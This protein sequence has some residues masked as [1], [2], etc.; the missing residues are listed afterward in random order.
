MPEA[1]VRV[2]GRCISECHLA[3][4]TR[5]FPRN[6]IALP[7]DCILGD[8]FEDERLQ[9]ARFFHRCEVL[10]ALSRS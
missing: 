10:V 3:Q 4:V 2:L 5:S 8:L 7:L 9:Q 6:E 1:F